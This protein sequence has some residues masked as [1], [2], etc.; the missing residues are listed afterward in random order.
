MPSAAIKRLN[1]NDSTL[2]KVDLSNNSV[3]QMKCDDNTSAIA[4]A[5]VSNTACSEVVLSNCG[6][7]DAGTAKLADVLKTN[8]TITKLDLSKNKIGSAG[9]TSLAEALKVNKTLVE[10]NLLGQSQKFGD[11]CLTAIVEM[12]EENTTLL[13]IIWRLENKLSWKI[14]RALTRNKEIAR[15]LREGQDISDLDPATRRNYI[16]AIASPMPERH[17]S[18][19][20]DDAP[21]DEAPKPVASTP[22]RSSTLTSSSSPAPK[23][24]PAVSITNSEGVTEESPTF[25]HNGTFHS[26]TMPQKVFLEKMKS[27]LPEHDFDE[28]ITDLTRLFF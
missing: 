17:A 3:F 16:P 7:T 27:K 12:F 6:V 21:T 1:E 22:V 4:A 25:E 24:E 28:F 18:G 9:V 13:N 5:L 10:L 23:D 14:T 8:K 15:R 19:G 11:A 26:V 2:T 20:D